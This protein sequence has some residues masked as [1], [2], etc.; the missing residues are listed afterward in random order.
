MEKAPLLDQGD[1]WLCA[2]HASALMIDAWRVSEMHRKGGKDG[3]TLESIRAH[4]TSPLALALETAEDMDFPQWVP[5]QNTSDPLSDVAGRRGALVC[6]VLDYAR[7]GG[8]CVDELLRDNR[9]GFRGDLINKSLKIYLEVRRAYES[10]NRDWEETKAS[11][12]EKIHLLLLTVPPI[13]N[14]DEVPTIDALAKLLEDDIDSPYTVMSKLFLK[15]CSAKGGNRVRV[16]RLPSCETGVYAGLD[17]LG[18]PLPRD[19]LRSNRAFR[20]VRD[21][22]Q[23]KNALPIAMAICGNVLEEGR[24]FPGDSIFSDDCNQHW[25]LAIGLR[26]RAGQCQVLL[27]N[28]LLSSQKYSS[29]WELDRGDVWV[30]AKTLTRATYMTQGFGY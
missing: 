24:S 11:V 14:A 5:F 9:E 21:A 1:S 18:I 29:D 2:H 16:G 27:H 4:G 8:I 15:G 22:L 3:Q 20:D 7:D 13:A 30:D 12:A 28:S 25:I 26:E 19:P 23:A 10:S 17:L 6:P